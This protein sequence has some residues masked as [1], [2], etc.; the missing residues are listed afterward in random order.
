MSWNIG[1][2]TLEETERACEFGDWGSGAGTVC[3]EGTEG[4]KDAGRREGG[5]RNATRLEAETWPE[6]WKTGVVV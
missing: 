4:E 5:G 3:E 2:K 1:C 6:M